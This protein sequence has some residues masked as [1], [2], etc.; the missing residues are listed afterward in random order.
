M[1]ISVCRRVQGKVFDI[2]AFSTYFGNLLTDTEINFQKLPDETFSSDE[3][4]DITRA[5]KE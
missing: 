5:W 3:K 1:T 4:Y 2:K